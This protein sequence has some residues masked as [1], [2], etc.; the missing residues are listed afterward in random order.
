[1]KSSG[2]NFNYFPENKLTK[3]ASVMQFKR[4][5]VLFV[6][7]GGWA[8]ASPCLRHRVGSLRWLHSVYCSF[9]CIQQLLLL[10]CV[11]EAIL[12]APG[13]RVNGVK[14]LSS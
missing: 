10:D 1:M 12:H 8:P 7:L 6:G 5:L 14:R 13:R 3:L 9:S 2:N 11:D 4:M